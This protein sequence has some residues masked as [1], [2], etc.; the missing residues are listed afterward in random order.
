MKRSQ[1][2]RLV[3]LL[4][5]TLGASTGTESGAL[6]VGVAKVDMTPADPTG[7][8]DIFQTSY[9]GVH[10]KIYARAIAR[11]KTRLRIVRLS[12][13]AHGTLTTNLVWG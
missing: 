12:V 2:I 10:D 8:T 11:A 13:E 1:Q 5:L 7:L 4:L 9:T 6:R 3:C